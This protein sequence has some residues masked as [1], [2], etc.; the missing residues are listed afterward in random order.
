MFTLKTTI[1]YL[2]I[3]IVIFELCF[4]SAN[5][6]IE[7]I[8]VPSTTE[9]TV[10]KNDFVYYSL[11]ISSP[12]FTNV[13]FSLKNSKTGS[14][15]LYIKEGSEPNKNSYTQRDNSNSK[16]QVI[17]VESP[18]EGNL[19]YVGVYGKNNCNFKLS[20]EADYNICANSDGSCQIINPNTVVETPPDVSVFTTVFGYDINIYANNPSFKTVLMEVL[21]NNLTDFYYISSDDDSG[22][23]N[24]SPIY[25]YHLS[26]SNSSLKHA[27]TFAPRTGFY[28]VAF[29]I[30]D[31]DDDEDDSLQY[32]FSYNFT[33]TCSSVCS[34]RGSCQNHVCVCSDPHTYTGYNCGTLIPTLNLDETVEG[35]AEPTMDNTYYL[36]SL[37]SDK[38]LQIKLDNKG[39]NCIL[40]VNNDGQLLQTSNYDRFIP[41]NQNMLFNFTNPGQYD[42]KWE[43][44]VMGAFGSYC[45]HSITASLLSWD[46]FT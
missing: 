31:Y 20:V 6:S 21:Y 45:E 44:V 42:G 38:T 32:S 35:F 15:A 22:D 16:F 10:S 9:G 5:Q 1:I 3:C 41:T 18:I 23:G 30:E 12:W 37:D 28:A 19:Y 25:V 43:I 46:L 27:V 7:G 13:T 26:S 24:Y 36:N 11:N 14:C 29:S 39:K 2:I 4:T 33:D 8:I 40:T 34:Q 17:T